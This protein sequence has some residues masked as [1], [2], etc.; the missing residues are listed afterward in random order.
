MR[1]LDQIIEQVND[2]A[3]GLASLLRKCLVLAAEIKSERLRIWATNELN[4]YGEVDDLPQYRMVQI[5]ARGFFVGP[6]RAQ[7]NNQPLPSLVLDENHRW[8]ATTAML[9]EPVASYEAMVR[10]TK[11]G[12]AQIPWP[13]DMVAYYQTKFFSGYALN[14]AWQ[15][16][17]IGMVIGIVDTVRTRLLQLALEL[18]DDTSLA[19]ENSEDTVKQRTDQ[20]VQ[21]IIYG[22]MNI[23]GSSVTGD[24]QF[25][26]QQLV[27]EGDFFS[28][29]NALKQAGVPDEEVKELESAIADDRNDGAT[30]GFG[31]RVAGWL[32]K[33][34]T[35]VGKEGVKVAADVSKKAITPLVMSYFGI[36]A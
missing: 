5:T 18:R 21:T 23:V 20:V 17:P 22:G 10:E 1:L 25:V 34:G 32:K 14:R 28:L 13:A 6:M 16:I 4:G 31:K 7:I 35:Y 11:D 24:V 12:A 33:A 8:W 19:E 2:D 36:A 15:E 27:V 29:S 30:D 9:N 3:I 26:G